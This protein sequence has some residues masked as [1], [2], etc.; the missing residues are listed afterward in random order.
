MAIFTD[1]SAEYAPLFGRRSLNLGHSLHKHALF[2]DDALAEL[3]ER[4]PRH[5]YHVNTMDP[6][7]HD[8]RTRREGEINGLSGKHTLNAISTG[9]IWLNLRN[10]GDHIPAYAEL[11]E[12]IYE[13]LHERVT[14]FKTFKQRMTILISS[15]KIQVYY[16]ADVP[17]QSLWQIRGTKRVWL[18][19]NKPPFLPQDGIERIVLG[20]AH[21]ISLPYEKWFD[22][23]AEVADLEAGRMMHW[24]HNCPHR[25]TNHDCLNISVTTEHWTKQL[26]NTYVANYANGILRKHLGLQDLSQ[27]SKGASFYGK[28]GLAALYK[29]SGLQKKSA[30]G[31]NINFRVDPS[32][33]DSVA[34]IPEYELRK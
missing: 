18:Y 32:A 19:P 5:D 9:L 27:S 4:T 16:H 31:F 3:I 24:P 6:K 7:T 15:P 14:D 1:W 20:K 10:P 2:T 22:E 8:P 28:L 29:F 11:L 25:V 34:D 21:E 33:P 26:R 17:G 13:E 30:A 23:H 12:Q